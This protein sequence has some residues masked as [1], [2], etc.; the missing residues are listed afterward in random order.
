M[1]KII[2]IICIFSL[3]YTGEV[4]SQSSDQNYIRKRVYQNEDAT[5][6]LDILNY[7]N[8]I[9]QL[10]QTIQKGVTPTGKDL[11]TL[12]EYDIVGRHTKS[13]LPVTSTGNGDHVNP[14]IIKNPQAL[15]NQDTSPYSEALYQPTPLGDESKRFGPG[16]NWYDNNKSIRTTYLVNDSSDSL[17][18]IAF[19]V[20]GSG[21]NTRLNKVSNLYPSG[22]L[23][24]TRVI[25]EDD[26]V[27]YTFKDKS[28]KIL[29]NRQVNISR[30]NNK[31]FLDT[32]MVYD[33]AGSLCYV[34][35]PL[36]K[37]KL[38][39]TVWN[40]DNQI[41]KEHVYVYKY[42]EKLRCVKKRLPGTDW[43]YQVFDQKDRIVM[44]QDGQDRLENKWI[45]SVYDYFDQVIEQSIVTGTLSRDFIQER[46][47]SRGYYNDLPYL[48]GTNNIHKPFSDDAF[49]VVDVLASIAYGNSRYEWGY[50]VKEA[51]S[52]DLFLRYNE[53][54]W[55][56]GGWIWGTLSYN[57]DYILEDD[58]VN[59]VYYICEDPDEPEV[60]YYYIPENFA[61]YVETLF[62]N[63]ALAYFEIL[64]EFPGSGSPADS[65][66]YINN[67]SANYQILKI[68]ERYK[69]VEIPGLVSLSDKNE[70]P[71]RLKTFEKLLVLDGNAEKSYIT[72]Y[73][74]YDKKNRVI[75]IAEDNIAGGVSRTSYKYDFNG[76][77]L[78]IQEIHEIDTNNTETL[79]NIYEYDHAG[80]MTSHQILM[81]NAILAHVNF[82]YDELGRLSEKEYKS[83][84]YTLGESIDYNIRG[85]L[86][87]KSS[88][89]FSMLLNYE[90]S[91]IA[92]VRRYD[93]SISEWIW[94][95]GTDIQ[96][97]YVFKYDGINQLLEAIPYKN[98][99][100]S[101]VA[102]T[103]NYTERNISYDLN[104]NILSLE[105]T[106]NGSLVDNLVYSYS[107]NQLTSLTENVTGN[108]VGDIYS[109]G[110]VATGMYT[111]DL[112][113]NMITDSRKALEI[114]YN[115]LN[116]VQQVKKGDNVHVNY[117]F[118]ANGIKLYVRDG[119]NVNG[120]DYIG[121]MVFKKN[122][123]GYQLETVLFE[124][125][126]IQV[127]RSGNN[128]TRS[129]NYFLKDHLG[130]IRAIING[131]GVVQERNDY[132]PFGARHT[133]GDYAISNNR[134]KYNGKE[135]QT[136][137]DL[138]YL[139]YGVRMYDSGLG[140]WF[141]V[142]IKAEAFYSWS[143]YTYVMN[144]PI[145]AV[146][147]K[148]DSV[149][150]SIENNI[151]MMHVTGKVINRSSDNINM[152]RA[153]KDIASSISRAFG[154]EFKVNGKTYTMKTDVQITAVTSMDDVSSSDHLFVLSDRIE[155]ADIAGRAA[156]NEIG[157]KVMSVWSGDFAD[158]DW[159][160]N[161]LS[162]NKT[163]SA[164]HE[165]GHALG[166]THET[167]SGWRNLMSQGSRGSNVSSDQRVTA[168]YN[169][170]QGYLNRG[171]NSMMIRGVLQPNPYYK[172]FNY[173][174]KRSEVIHI[175]SI[176][177]NHKY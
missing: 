3:G 23:L 96:Q 127:N 173:A 150:F 31:R 36:A 134:Y 94:K 13:W 39:G 143:P 80:R 73:Y 64:N 48:G 7:Y 15:Y 154:G 162:Y 176:G 174:R 6:Y 56:G 118:L 120:Y 63:D 117:T 106:A 121:S 30:D 99:G 2:Y 165:F 92:N 60:R 85:W 104:G 171:Y 158:N 78:R 40:D 98:S 34:I 111:Y 74:Y 123:V 151:A 141:G 82:H 41:I 114:Q 138:D 144:N 76:R 43:V 126:V 135:E 61:P 44:T 125:G 69:F 115:T 108:P 153:A 168:V 32:Y 16:Q 87:G 26:N 10:I 129:V 130:S 72:R 49:S 1:K 50:L 113:G 8:G 145:N 55:V 148:G 12:Q 24:V 137:G 159:L 45:Y 109:R 93:G 147:L 110:N 54:N 62:Y 164:V 66:E 51:L 70:N 33:N 175:N 20:S 140:R 11:V 89:V 77:V 52:Q 17:A 38:I 79:D 9:G 95:Q 88:P 81:G 132:Y 119:N 152:T 122:S 75:Q 128:V 170:Q 58:S 84:N 112:N 105:R 149:W 22:E 42:D 28:G 169:Y 103:N 14:V 102:N 86:T 100:T 19:V 155:S 160:G 124:D 65:I 146:D 133:R 90:I 53:Y 4:L 37:E 57:P 21:M 71:R 131:S 161:N 142:D 25:N 139:D 29:L 163:R 46:F 35:P 18:C 47:D 136:T 156:T 67:V 172:Y 167:A 5:R 83:G 59:P 91:N 166:L 107:G 101:W 116:L 177:L 97:M 27:S 68:P 157:G